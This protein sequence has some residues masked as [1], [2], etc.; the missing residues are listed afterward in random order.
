MMRAL[1]ILCCQVI[2]AV[3]HADSPL[4]LDATV[5]LVE[6]LGE[7]GYVHLRLPSGAVAIAEIRGETGLGT[8][9]R[10]SL[11]LD[12]AHLHLFGADGR[13]IA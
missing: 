9:D 1:L 12:P 10:A 5:E 6:R 13:R 3:A 2:S 7:M 8:G 4:R 11:A